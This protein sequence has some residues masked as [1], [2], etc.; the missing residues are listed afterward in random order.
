MVD[1][2]RF[3]ILNQ[4]PLGAATPDIPI[5]KAIKKGYFIFIC[6]LQRANKPTLVGLTSGIAPSKL[7]LLGSSP[8][9]SAAASV[10]RVLE[11]RPL[12]H[13]RGRA[14]FAQPR[15]DRGKYLDQPALG[16]VGQA[17]PRVFLFAFPYQLTRAPR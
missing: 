9:Q 12:K 2:P 16:G 8:Y 17:Q 7:D 1:F 4:G 15:L 6:M 10:D 11:S 3:L 13:S 14:W 5:I